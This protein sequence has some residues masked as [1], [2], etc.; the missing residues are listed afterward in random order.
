MSWKCRPG[1]TS[2][3]W[4][5][6]T[7]RGMLP[8]TLTSPTPLPVSRRNSA[9]SRWL[10]SPWMLLL[11]L[12]L[13]F[14]LGA[15]T[16]PLTD[17]DEGAF[18]EATREMLAADNLVSPTLNG[19]PRHDKPILIYWAQAVSVSV[20]GIN[21]LGFRLPSLIAAVLWVLATGLFCARYGRRADAP[22]AMLVMTLS[23]MVG[24]IAKAAIAD[25]LLNLW[26]A[27]SM[28]GIRGRPAER[29][30]RG[31]ACTAADGAGT[32][33]G[34]PDQGAGGADVSGAG[35]WAL[36]VV[37]PAM[38]ADPRCTARFPGLVVAYCYGF[39]LA[40]AGLS[41]SGGC[42]FPRVLPAAQ[43]QSLHQHLRGAR[44]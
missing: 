36:P 32:R 28:F 35:R 12:L 27:L 23:L 1:V 5:G 41:R 6:T 3:S 17:V 7:L 30:R 4:A 43:R 44:R 42:L 40:C 24:M 15:A 19:Q 22:V 14:F 8:T 31:E 39:A 26:L 20:L 9:L 21:E 34:L 33:A 16:L 18:T 29:W 2:R 25:A 38:A 11:A 13:S 10:S 37:D